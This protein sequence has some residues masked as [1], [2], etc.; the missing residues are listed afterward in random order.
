MTGVSDTQ[1]ISGAFPSPAHIERNRCKRR[2]RRRE[3]EREREKKGRREREG[4]GGER[5]RERDRERERHGWSNATLPEHINP[6]L[7]SSFLS[8]YSSVPSSQMPLY[9]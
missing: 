1:C 9:Q 8:T 5:K 6:V 2:E 7:P 3:G 4:R